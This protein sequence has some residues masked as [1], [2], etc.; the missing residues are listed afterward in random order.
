MDIQF[1]GGNKVAVSTSNHVD[2]ALGDFGKTLKENVM[3]HATSQLFTITSEAN[4]LDDEK[5]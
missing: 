5:N 4:E 2:E 3:N 1:I